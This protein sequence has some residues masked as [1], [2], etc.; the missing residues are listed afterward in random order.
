MAD[1]ESGGWGDGTGGKYVGDLGILASNWYAYGGT[2]DTSPSAQI[3]V[4]MRITGGWV[5]DQNGCA[6][7]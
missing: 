3:A 5:P 7:W 6:S 2:S 4:G 1:C